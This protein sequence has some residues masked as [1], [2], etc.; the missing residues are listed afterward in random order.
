MISV[1]DI[2]NIKETLRQRVINAIE[3]SGD[4]SDSEIQ[5][6]IDHEIITLQK[7]AAVSY[8][9][10]KRL[11]KEIFYA[12]RKLDILQELLDTPEISEIMIN[13]TDSIFI[14]RAGRLLQSEYRFESP[15]KLAHVIQ[16]IVAD[17][18]RTV[19]EAS[20][21]V[22]ARLKDG[23]RVNIVLAPVALNGPIVTIRRFP[24]DPIVMSDLL[25][26]EALTPEMA[27]YL[28]AAVKGGESIIISGGTGSGKTT[29]LNVLSNF[30]PSHE[31]IITIE[32]SAE[33][34]IRNIPN[35]VKLETRG[36]NVEGCR[37]ITI[38]DL[39]KSALRM[40]PDR[41]VVGEVRGAEA[42]DLLQAMN[43]GHP[44]SMSTLHA[45]HAK[46]MVSRLETMVLMGT[47]LP[48]AAIRKQ[49]ASAVQLVV[50]LGRLGD[51]SRR[52][53]EIAKLVGIK[54][55]DIAMEPVFRLREV[56][57]D[58]NGRIRVEWV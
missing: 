5:E 8:E 41:I 35:I 23:A 14:E 38:R 47:P 26:Y 9:T 57:E 55:D 51:S 24:E 49:I 48:L 20:P 42:L 45:N 40:R 36:A 50:Q 43:T 44:G 34:Q 10:R 15:E 7:S 13:G 22:D 33:L 53:L 37:E 39:I 18:N 17:C 32:D 30:I 11:R 56:G 3:S 1:N 27:A 31:R 21:I 16:H 19:N 28:E 58:E 2:A 46:D 29:F 12:I 4:L 25:D 52:V 54:K 6:I